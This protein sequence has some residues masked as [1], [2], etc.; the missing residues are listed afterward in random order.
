MSSKRGAQ[1]LG[2]LELRVLLAVLHCGDEA[3]GVT[4]SREIESRTEKAL[5]QGAVYVTLERLEKKG[6]LVSR[7]GDPTAVRG[8]RAKRLF[9]VAGGIGM[10]RYPSRDRAPSSG[11]APV[12]AMR[13]H[14]AR[15]I[16]RLFRGERRCR[17]RRSRRE[18]A[19]GKRSSLV[20]APGSRELCPQRGLA[21]A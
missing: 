21:D 14:P 19:S 15:R 6:L 3:Y 11:L 18:R 9:S 20:L 8:G 2:D 10:L 5:S 12:R 1:G 13:S 17:S 4:V 16:L 7:L